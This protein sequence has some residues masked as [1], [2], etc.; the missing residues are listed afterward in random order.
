MQKLAILVGQIA[1]AAAWSHVAINK[2]SEAGCAEGS[3]KAQNMVSLKLLLK[4]VG[5]GEDYTMEDCVNQSTSA[6][7]FSQ[8]FSCKA[9]FFATDTYMGDECEGSKKWSDASAAFDCHKGDPEDEWTS[10]ACDPYMTG[11]VD[12]S[13]AQYATNDCSGDPSMSM[14]VPVKTGSCTPGSELGNGTWVIKSSK[15]T[16]S[17][18]TVTKEEFS[19]MDCSGTA[20][21]STPQTCGACSTEEGNHLL[22]TC[23]SE[24]NNPGAASGA[25]QPSCT[26]PALILL[27]AGAMRA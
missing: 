21:T 24:P 27:A 9:G 14:E 3:L 4:G 25:F 22:F 8:K 6:I 2:Y 17:G 20:S 23:P 7:K 19:T 16:R 13:M 5:A 18:E 15:M 1:V 12:Y 26:L 11:Y 10:M